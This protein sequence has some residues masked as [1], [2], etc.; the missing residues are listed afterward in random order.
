[1]TVIFDLQLH[2][3]GPH[4]QAHLDAVRIGVLQCIE[5]NW[6]GERRRRF[7]SP[8]SGMS[9]GPSRSVPVLASVRA[10]GF[11]HSQVKNLYRR[12]GGT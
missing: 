12:A 11:Y 6:E 2:C 8:R 1:V 4:R 10:T 9:A 7:K 5:A 3:G